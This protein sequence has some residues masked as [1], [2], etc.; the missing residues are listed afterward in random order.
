MLVE[1]KSE[2]RLHQIE[3]EPY[4]A[5]T[6]PGRIRRAG[7]DSSLFV[8]AVYKNKSHTIHLAAFHHVGRYKGDDVE[9]RE[10]IYTLLDAIHRGKRRLGELEDELR[11]HLEAIALPL[12]RKEID[13]LCRE[14]GAPSMNWQNTKNLPE[15]VIPIFKSRK[16]FPS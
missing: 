12:L 10:T 9:I 2:G 13:E 15:N 5:P 8:R 7:F 4:I 14:R 11:A 16:W 1:F 3:V 6:P